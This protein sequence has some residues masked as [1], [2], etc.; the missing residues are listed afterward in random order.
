MEMRMNGRNALITGGSQGIGRA[1]AKKFADAGANVAIV[2]RNQGG[3][4]EAKAEIAAQARTRKSSPSPPT[5]ARQR[6]AARPMRRRPRR[7]A[8]STCS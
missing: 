6:A 3:L 2:A 1:V 5:S 8:R 7:S 4:D